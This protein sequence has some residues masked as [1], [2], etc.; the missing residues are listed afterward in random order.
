MFTGRPE[1]VAQGE[2]TG[3]HRAWQQ[4]EAT[5]VERDKANTHP[6]SG[7]LFRGSF[8]AHRM[9]LAHL[10]HNHHRWHPD[11]IVRNWPEQLAAPIRDAEDGVDRCP[12]CTWELEDGRCQHCGYPVDLTDDTDIGFSDL[13][14]EDVDR[15]LGLEDDDDGISMDVDIEQHLYEHGLLPHEDASTQYTGSPGPESYM[16]AS[17][18]ENTGHMASDE[19]S[20][21][22]DD[23]DDDEEGSMRDFIDDAPRSSAPMANTS[24]TYWAGDSSDSDNSSLPRTSANIALSNVRRSRRPI[25][26]SSDSEDDSEPEADNDSDGDATVR[27]S[28]PAAASQT[29]STEGVLTG[30]AIELRASSDD[31]DGDGD[32]DTDDEPIPPTRRL[33]RT[34]HQYRAR[35]SMYL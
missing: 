32:D 19:E 26:H 34:I 2:T 14:D 8:K 33:H 1:L 27:E 16:T 31:D 28:S 15:D 29:S 7:G 11:A 25:V 20:D 10:H 4:E 12:N 18:A 17:D 30:N 6:I 35:V 21:N 23:G 22:D 24:R 13:S 3:Q 5:V 9:S